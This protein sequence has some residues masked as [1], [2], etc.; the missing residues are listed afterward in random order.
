VITV[1]PIESIRVE[2]RHRTD[3]G[4]LCGLAASIKA[5]GLLHPVV[6]TAENSLIT[7]ERRLAACRSL[8]WSEIPV[9]VAS[10]LTEA[11][12]LL[13]AEADENVQRKDFTPTEAE[14]IASAREALLR[15]LAEQRMTA[16]KPPAPGANFAQGKTREVAAIGTGFSHESLRKVRDVKKVADDDSAPEPVRAAAKLAL[17]DMD[18]SGKVDPHHKRVRQAAGACKKLGIS[19]DDYLARPPKAA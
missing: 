17:A 4:D 1:L 14:S 9:N 16:G 3:L 2:S 5:V 19:I 11:A 10:N 6:V 18:R 7:G 8:G 13:R 15:P 12:D